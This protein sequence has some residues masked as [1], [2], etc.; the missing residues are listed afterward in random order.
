MKK[1]FKIGML[2]SAALPIA[3]I[4]S[5]GSESTSSVTPAA[6]GVTL[7][8]PAAQF[9]STLKPIAETNI[10]KIDDVF[11]KAMEDKNGN[12]NSP[13]F[14][15]PS[16]AGGVEE[17]ELFDLCQFR[18]SVKILAKILK[19]YT[20]GAN[21]GNIKYLGVNG[22]VVAATKIGIT[23]EKM[24]ALLKGKGYSMI[25]VT[26]G[27]GN[28]SNKKQYG[29]IVETTKV[30]ALKNTILKA[31]G[32]PAS[33]AF[34]GVFSSITQEARN[35]SEFPDS[36]NLEVQFTVL[37]ETDDGLG[38]SWNPGD[39]DDM[40]F[41]LEMAGNPV[42]N[43]EKGILFRFSNVNVNREDFSSTSQTATD[44]ATKRTGNVVTASTS[45]D[46]GV[47]AWP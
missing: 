21:S 25:D 22:T 42:V 18:R 33:T 28:T 13:K 40:V 35:D 1:I 26:I 7:A 37:D 30:D 8:S 5:C 31:D 43:Q 41:E 32:Q 20:E 16:Q 15:V 19:D 24:V 11:K 9:D 36:S 2:A 17:F 44:S 14:S 3:T 47:Y 34:A 6:T 4:I 46:A 39:V 10:T 12:T 38:R 23:A 29:L 45:T 27:N